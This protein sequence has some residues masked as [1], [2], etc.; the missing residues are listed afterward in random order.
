MNFLLEYFGLIGLFSLFEWLCSCGLF[1][2][3]KYQNNSD[4]RFDLSI[5]ISN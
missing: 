2:F 3:K 5:K 1:V 4:L